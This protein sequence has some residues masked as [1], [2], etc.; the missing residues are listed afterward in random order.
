MLKHICIFIISV[1]LG[2]QGALAVPKPSP[3]LVRK[4]INQQFGQS[5]MFFKPYDLP[6]EFERSHT[7]MVKKLDKWVKL[8]LVKQIKTRFLAEKMMYGSIREV[9]VGGYE[10][11]LNMASPW[12]SE[13]GVF[14]GKPVVLDILDISPPSHMNSDY[15]CEVYFSWYAADIPEWV[16]KINLKDREYRQLRRAAESRKKPF[17]K[18]LYF[19]L[20]DNQW[21][22][23]NEKGKQTLF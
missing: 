4:L 9:S 13:K 19:I 16:E 18:R 21:V 14:Y 2:L 7:A 10:Y 1:G 17:E 23:W 5:L 22:L 11:T 15:F 6:V 3:E 12:V 20:R 8:G